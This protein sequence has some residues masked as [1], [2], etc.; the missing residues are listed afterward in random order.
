M[1]HPPVYAAHCVYLPGPGFLSQAFLG[2]CCK[3][4]FILMR[5]Y[6]ARVKVVIVV[7]FFF[8]RGKGTFDL[9]SIKKFKTETSVKALC[10]GEP[11][12]CEAELFLPSVC[13]GLFLWTRSAPDT[14]F[15]GAGRQSAVFLSFHFFF[16]H[17]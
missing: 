10:R 9:V 2:L 15:A 6:L 11:A 12:T 1:Q 16:F 4:D 3:K 14:L 17:S 7:V 8:A 5:L 13:L